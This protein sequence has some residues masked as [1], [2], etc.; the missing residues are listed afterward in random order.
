MSTYQ[1]GRSR[2]RSSAIHNASSTVKRVM[3][4]YMRIISMVE[5]PSPLSP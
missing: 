2:S 5:S 4:T 1:T 3:S